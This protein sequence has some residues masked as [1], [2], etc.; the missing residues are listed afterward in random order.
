MG[1]VHVQREREREREYMCVCVCVCV[2]EHSKAFLCFILP[3]ASQ[4]EDWIAQ[5][6]GSK[7]EGALHP[8][9]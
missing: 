4:A 2:L 6:L 9:G 5:R 8:H 3:K 7:E 1:C